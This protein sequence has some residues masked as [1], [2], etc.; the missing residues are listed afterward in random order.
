[1]EY[2]ILDLEWNNTYAHKLHGFF[3][4]IIQFGAVR[5]DE[6]LH[7]IARYDTF[8]C[9][10]AAGKLTG[11]VEQ[12]TNITNDDLKTGIPFPQA[13]RQ[14]CDF[15][16]GSVLLTW[17]DCDLRELMNNYRYFTGT[18]ELPLARP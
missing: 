17:G 3:N 16:A 9:P 7:E 18:A 12:L 14:F 15:A 4:E 8:V 2:T 5:L 13:F 6:K 10:D 11:M 1:M